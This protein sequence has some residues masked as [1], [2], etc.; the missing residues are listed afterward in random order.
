M[1][2]LK[3]L[4]YS[5]IVMSSM[6]AYSTIYAQNPLNIAND[7]ALDPTKDPSVLYQDLQYE[8]QMMEIQDFVEKPGATLMQRFKHG[9]IGIKDIGILLIRAINFLT[10][11]AGT[12]AVVMFI[13]SGFMKMVDNKGWANT[14]SNATYG[15]VF[16]FLAWVIV[17]F[18]ITFMTS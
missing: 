1:K 4:V 15:L 13:Y 8:T 14:F 18:I 11:F 3:R 10:Y 5:V 9:E 7:T 6:C 17:N 2:L 16:T 12:I